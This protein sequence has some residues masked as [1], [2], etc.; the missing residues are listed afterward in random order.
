MILIA[1][2]EILQY[3]CADEWVKNKNPDITHVYLGIV[4]T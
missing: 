4:H 2:L 3:I 1:Q